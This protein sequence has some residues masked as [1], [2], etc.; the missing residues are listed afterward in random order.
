MFHI[1][2]YL[3]TIAISNKVKNRFYEHDLVLVENVSHYYFRLCAQ[4]F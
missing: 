3:T 1:S 4:I 2:I